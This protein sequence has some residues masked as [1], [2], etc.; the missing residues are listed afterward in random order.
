MTGASFYKLKN[1]F[2]T[3]VSDFYKVVKMYLMYF[4]PSRTTSI[5]VNSAPFDLHPMSV[6]LFILQNRK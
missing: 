1:T 3:G 4:H 6:L 2:V 5:P